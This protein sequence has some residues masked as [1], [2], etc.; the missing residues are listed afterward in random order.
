ML[1]PFFTL[2][3]A[4]IELA[5]KIVEAVPC[6]EKIRFMTTGSEAVSS[7]IRMARAFTGRDKLLR[8]EG[9]WHGVSDTVGSD[10][11]RIVEKRQELGMAV[12]TDYEGSAVKGLFDRLFHHSDHG[13]DD[14]SDG[15]ALDSR[16]IDFALPE[17][18]FQKESLRRS[19]NRDCRSGSDIVPYRSD[20]VGDSAH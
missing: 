13:R 7:A 2:N 19:I 14:T 16:G 9:G 15:G 6:G 18:I 5:E 11:A 10:F 17:K 1:D 20:S 8:F 4:I 12:G 3:T